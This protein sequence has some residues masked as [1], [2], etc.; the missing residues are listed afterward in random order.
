MPGGKAA[1]DVLGAGGSDLPLARGAGMA[2]TINW[3]GE[4]QGSSYERLASQRNEQGQGKRRK[5]LRVW[6]Y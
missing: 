3:R 5:K 6:S 1:E 4:S 2:T